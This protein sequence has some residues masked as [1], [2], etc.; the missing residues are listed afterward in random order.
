M[1]ECLAVDCKSDRVVAGLKAG[2]CTR[3]SIASLARLCV[4]SGGAGGVAGVNWWRSC[5]TAEATTASRYA[6]AAG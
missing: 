6:D 3:W 2:F 4:L 5:G 1:G